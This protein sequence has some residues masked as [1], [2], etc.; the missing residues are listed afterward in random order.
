MSAA[1]T[2]D[3]TG[4]TVPRLIDIR[5]SIRDTLRSSPAFGP[6][7]RLGP[8]SVI[9]QI[10]DALAPEIASVYSLAQAIYDSRSR[11]SAEGVPLDTIGAYTGTVRNPA[12]YSTGLINPTGTAATP[13]PAGSQVRVPDGPIFETTAAGTIGGDDIP[14]RAVETGPVEAVSGSITEIVTAVSGWT[15]VDNPEDVIVGSDV[16]S[17][18]AYRI[19]QERDLNSQGAGT[20][21]AIRAALEAIESVSAAASISGSVGPA[22]GVTDYAYETA[23]IVWPI[24]ADPAEVAAAIWRNAP[25]GAVFVGDETALVTDDQGYTQLIRFGFAAAQNVYITANVITDSDYPADGDDQVS[26]VLVA[27][28]DTLS[29]GDDVL[30]TQMICAVVDSV[31]GVRDVEILANVGSAPS[32]TDDLPIDISIAEIADISSLRVT[33]VST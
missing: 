29:I 31:D 9:G 14:I 32:A 16:E 25:S 13:I 27:Y 8:E 7:A 33:V 21:A 18:S 6:E 17:D 26:A 12:T 2:L 10:V 19:R 30:P 20:D 24:T 28:G 1:A 23:A 22:Y 15:G 4:L 3:A 11:D 5:E